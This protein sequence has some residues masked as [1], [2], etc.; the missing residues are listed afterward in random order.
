MEV[1]LFLGAGIGKSFVDKIPQKH[2]RKV[3]VVFL[4]LL[5][6]SVRCNIV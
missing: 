4:L 2:L 5:G 6:M 1:L 3:F